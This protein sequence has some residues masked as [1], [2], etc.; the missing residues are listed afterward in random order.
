MVEVDVGNLS[1]IRL[2]SHLDAADLDR[3]AKACGWR[4]YSAHEQIIDRQ[5]DTR[6]VF[7]VVSGKVRV[8]NYSITGRLRNLMSGNLDLS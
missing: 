5:S 4:S 7:F 8:V 2:L 6:D 1:T 3:V